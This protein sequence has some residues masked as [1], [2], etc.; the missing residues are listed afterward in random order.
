MTISYQ[1]PKRQRWGHQVGRLSPLQ[2]YDRFETF[3]RD[4]AVVV[5][6]CEP[7]VTVI[8][9][10]T[11]SFFVSQAVGTLPPSVDGTEDQN[12]GPFYGKTYRR[13]TRKLA[14][15][16]LADAIAWLEANENQI[17]NRDIPLQSVLLHRFVHFR[18]R[19]SPDPEE[20]PVSLPNSMI[21][22]YYSRP[23]QISTHL[24]FVYLQQYR[25]LK[26]YLLELGLVKLS[27]KHIRPKRAISEDVTG[28]I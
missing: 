21:G 5:T 18:W 14:P 20:A 10:P 9:S 28:T 15:A 4:K 7:E 27:D 22:I 2:I 17:I 19:N 25:E 16:S 3:L 6:L 1:P 12:E 23:R 8:W 11:D 24:H 13:V 26:H